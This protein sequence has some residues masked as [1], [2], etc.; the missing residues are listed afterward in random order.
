MFNLA[1]P[2]VRA[3]TASF[4]CEVPSARAVE[5][6][7]SCPAAPPSLSVRA[8][9]LSMEM[10]STFTSERKLD[11]ATDIVISSENLFTSAVTSKY[12]GSSIPLRLS[13]SARPGIASPTAIIESP[14]LVSLPFVISTFENTSAGSTIPVIIVKGTSFVLF[15]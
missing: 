5:P 15:V 8:F 11:V 6:S 3:G 14:F 7:T 12:S 13:I 1:I 2:S 9:M 10:S 4:N